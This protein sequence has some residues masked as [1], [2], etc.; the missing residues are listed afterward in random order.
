MTIAAKPPR[1]H[2]NA[3]SIIISD[4]TYYNLQNTNRHKANKMMATDSDRGSFQDH[5]TKFTSTGSNKIPVGMRGGE[6]ALKDRG[7]YEIGPNAG[8]SHHDHPASYYQNNRLNS[9]GA[10]HDFRPQKQESRTEQDRTRIGLAMNKQSLVN[11]NNT[12]LT[13]ILETEDAQAAHLK[14]IYMPRSVGRNG[15][16]TS[17]RRSIVTEL[18]DPDNGI[19]FLDECERVYNPRNQKTPPPPMWGEVLE[20]DLYD[21]SQPFYDHNKAVEALNARK[22]KLNKMLEQDK[23]IREAM[24][25]GNHQQIDSKQLK[26]KV[27]YVYDDEANTE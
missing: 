14:H 24:R 6:V 8:L 19:V 26:R 18:S 3:S 21:H 22:K 5:M 2:K 12:K 1:P 16:P 23:Q 4:D 15:D 11:L 10:M 17:S 13:P 25:A 20:E 9:R 27:I 7:I